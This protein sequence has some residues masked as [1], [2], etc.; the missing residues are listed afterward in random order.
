MSGLLLRLGARA[1]GQVGTVRAAAR[2]PFAAPPELAPAWS[3]AIASVT[4]P[5]V[6]VTG[7]PAT[8]TRAAPPDAS[9]PL[10][11]VG[12]P[13]RRPE[14]AS[15]PPYSAIVELPPVTVAAPGQTPEPDVVVAV[16]GI[17]AVAAGGTQVRPAGPRV[18]ATL[19]PRSGQR[20]ATAPAAPA[21]GSPDSPPSES[22]VGRTGATGSPESRL[23]V[24]SSMRV[25]EPL[26]PTRPLAR[27]RAWSSHATEP[28]PARDRTAGGPAGDR[29]EETTEVHVS[30]GRIEVTAVHETAAPRRPAPPRPKVMT[31]DAYLAGRRGGQQ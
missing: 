12:D 20:A 13:T 8:P 17:E 16:P 9:I 15:P 28:A 27:P 29:A 7:A 19:A 2:M 14:P 11:A 31:L 25:I 21:L 30:I 5:A 10:S 1:I 26:L 3:E 23:P 18:D 22:P 4:A 24:R 6:T